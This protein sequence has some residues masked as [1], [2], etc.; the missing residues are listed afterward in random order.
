MAKLV[1][2]NFTS[3]IKDKK[4]AGADED[5]YYLQLSNEIWALTRPLMPWIEKTIGEIASGKKKV[6]G[7][8]AFLQFCAALSG[9]IVNQYGHQISAKLSSH[10]DEVIGSRF[11]QLAPNLVPK[12]MMTLS[13]R[14]WF[15]QDIFSILVNGLR[16]MKTRVNPKTGL[17]ASRKDL[18]NKI[19][20]SLQDAGIAAK[21]SLTAEATRILNEV[22]RDHLTIIPGRFQP[23]HLG[24]QKMSGGTD[25]YP[26]Y[27]IIKGA[28]SSSD[29]DKNPFSVEDQ[30]RFIKKAMGSRAGVM[31]ATSAYIPALVEQV[32]AE[33]G[34]K[35]IEVIAGDDR[36]DDYRR[37]VAKT[38]LNNQIKF[39][40]AQRFASATT[41]RDAIKSGDQ[42]TFKKLMP[43]A[44]HSEY[45][46]MK[47]ILE[48]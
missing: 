21:S 19:I 7:A 30:K 25:G 40:L 46:K 1:D 35:V 48:S 36:V 9:Q 27:V 41:V 16:N 5:S 11:F 47:S 23:F 22:T 38:P 10:Q 3:Q 32:E 34:G 26:V 8:T 17:D 45:E 44:L 14:F 2:P 13:N 6:S 39:S 4:A 29:K 43:S 33:M 37:Q 24:H 18:M 42:E 31:V 20:Q 15:A 28:K 12:G